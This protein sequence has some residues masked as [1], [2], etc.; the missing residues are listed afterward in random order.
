MRLLVIALLLLALPVQAEWYERE[1]SSMGTKI[2]VR[3]WAENAALGEQALD[4]AF[5]EMQR[6]DH[7]FSP[8][9]PASELSTVNRQAFDQ[10][11]SLSAELCGLIERSLQFSQLTQG[12]FDITFASVGFQYDYRQAKKPSEQQLQQ[13]LP[14]V[15]YR[16]ITLENCTLRFADKRVKIDLGGI[17]KGHAVDA[18]AA[19]M[20]KQGIE[21]A[22]IT[23]GGDSY[24]LGDRHGK[25]WVIGVRH[26]RDENNIVAVIPLENAALSTSGDYER[27]FEEN[28]VRYHHILNPKTGRSATGIQSVTII[29]DHGWRTDALSTS[30]FV[31]GVDK[32]LKLIND[33]AGIDAIII[34]GQGL[35]HYSD[36]LLRAAD[37]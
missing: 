20:Q 1:G 28:G 8:Y 9:K 24:L 32:G 16:L 11:V 6:I 27:F 33:L 5:A 3:L 19:L 4:N 36:E 23:A 34:D 26:P 35:L 7:A 15:N 21:N 30:V 25:P 37:R 22:S 12:A 10:P 17:A 2:H 18:V 13:S 31:L 29:G 14:A